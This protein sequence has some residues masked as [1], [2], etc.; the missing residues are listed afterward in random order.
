MNCRTS[1]IGVIRAGAD[2][3]SRGTDEKAIPSSA[4]VAPPSSQIQAKVNQP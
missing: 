4:H 3:P 2:S 1:T